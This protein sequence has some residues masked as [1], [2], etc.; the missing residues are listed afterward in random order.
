MTKT[1]YNHERPRAKSPRA[2]V[3]QKEGFAPLAARPG[4]QHTVLFSLRQSCSV[5]KQFARKP[6]APAIASTLESLLNS[7]HHKSSGTKNRPATFGA[8]RGIRTP[9]YIPA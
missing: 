4:E 9:V 7:V 3:A 1:A 5:Y 8:E 2:F 6:I